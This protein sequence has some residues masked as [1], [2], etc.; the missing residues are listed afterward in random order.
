MGLWSGAKSVVTKGLSIRIDKWMSLEHIE[1]TF[2]RTRL[3]VKDLFK[4]KKARYSET[5]EQ[6]M[7]RLALTDEDL[8]QRKREF[9]RLTIAFIVIAI[10]LLGYGA[11]W[12]FHGKA[13]ITL[14]ATFL[15]MYAFSQAF[16]FHFWLFQLRNK[17]LGCTFSEWF[18]SQIH[19][20]DNQSKAPPK[21]DSPG[22]D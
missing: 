18:N 6:A 12:L 13:W 7:E 16:R 4:P 11:Y 1:E 22:D 5:F 19:A 2:D 17:K 9:I 21:P 14:I 10:L 3:I 20:T 15:S 8:E